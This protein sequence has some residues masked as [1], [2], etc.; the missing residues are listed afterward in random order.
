MKLKQF[1]HFVIVIPLAV[2]LMSAKPSTTYQTQCVSLETDGYI[3]IKIW[4]TKKAENYKPE[5]ARKDAIYAI[6]YS[7]IAGENGCVTQSPLLIKLENEEKFSA[8]EK[9]FF[10]KSGKWSQFTRS[11][12]IETT[13]PSNIGAKEWKAYQVSISKKELIK[14]LE[15]KSIIDKPIIKSLNN[16]F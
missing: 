5:Q 8:I 4:D 6:L 10:S 2:L 3:I 16:G 7:G 14:Y 12:A 11:S 13:L 15:E 9:E 1:I